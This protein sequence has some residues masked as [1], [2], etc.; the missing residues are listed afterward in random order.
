MGVIK[1][2]GLLSIT[3]LLSC[4]GNNPEK[5]VNDF[6]TAISDK[7]FDMA[8]SLATEKSKSTLDL[9][10][11]GININ[12]GDGKL[13][14]VDCVTENEIATCDCFIEGKEKPIPVT[15]V[16]E[17]GEWK[18]D[19]QLTAKNMMNNFLDKLNGLDLSGID[20]K[21]IDV[22]GIMEN[23]GGSVEAGTNKLNEFLK[24][25]D[26]DKVSETLKGLDSNMGETSG[27]IEE[28]LK[29][30]EEGMGETE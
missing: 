3:L 14:N 26:A 8:K 12:F 5:T 28:L 2:I 18:V 29:K 6:F 1:F 9:L 17:N 11:S 19:I 4:S 21:N 25:I 16:K 24:N 13:K 23:I 22:E 10:E 27:N 7:D 30:I 15:V 20:L